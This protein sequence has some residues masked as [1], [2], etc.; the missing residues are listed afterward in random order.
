MIFGRLK[1]KNPRPVAVRLLP[2][3]EI[4]A[5]P[6]C[7][8][9]LKA[10]IHS[11]CTSYTRSVTGT[12]VSATLLRFR[13]ALKSPFASP[14]PPYSQ[15][16]RLSV[17]NRKMLLLFLIGLKQYHTILM[18]QLRRQKFCQVEKN[19]AANR[20]LLARNFVQ[21]DGIYAS[22][23]AVRIVGYCFYIVYCK[24]RPVSSAFHKIVQN[25]YK[26]I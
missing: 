26:S 23:C 22:K 18:V 6:P 13:L 11:T 17:G 10:D 4:P 12:P 16:R 2:G 20:N 9:Q 3:Q 5:V 1:T 19:F 7:L 25:L 14:I 15:H 8:S 21:H 24:N